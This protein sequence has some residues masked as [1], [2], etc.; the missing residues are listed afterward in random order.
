MILLNRFHSLFHCYTKYGCQLQLSECK[1]PDDWMMIEIPILAWL[2]GYQLDW[3]C[4][5]HWINSIIRFECWFFAHW[6]CVHLW[7][8]CNLNSIHKRK[9][10]SVECND[11]IWMG[12]FN[13][14]GRNVSI[15]VKHTR[16]AQLVARMLIAYVIMLLN[17]LTKKNKRAQ[18]NTPNRAIPGMDI[19]Y[20]WIP[21]WI[22]HV[23]CRTASIIII[24]IDASNE[25]E[26]S[27][28]TKYS[29]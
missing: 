18:L 17:I 19:Y 5:T 16:I 27:V 26:P 22:L 20:Y 28:N 7:F 9:H 6:R 8:K 14:F 4:F 11:F 13:D 10:V 25:I 21:L 23:C 3:R 24:F 15:G 1:T 2:S 12:K 29:I